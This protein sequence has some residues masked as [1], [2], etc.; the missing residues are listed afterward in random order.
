MSSQ[1]SY[2]PG[3]VLPPARASTA[4]APSATTTNARDQLVFLMSASLGTL[5]C[6]QYP[7]AVTAVNRKRHAPRAA[8]L[9]AEG[10]WPTVHEARP[11][12]PPAP[13]DL[14]RHQREP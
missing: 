12:R 14:G 2:F 10:R 9:V 1:S 13:Q 3:A 8:I 6:H 5:V 11:V 4:S 7:E